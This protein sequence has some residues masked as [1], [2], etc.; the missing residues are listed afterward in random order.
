MIAVV[1]VAA[2]L[3]VAIRLGPIGLVLS[4]P[5]LAVMGALWLVFRGR[6]RLAWFC[7]WVP[8]ILINFL[9]AGLCITPDRPRIGGLA[10]VWLV[11]VFPTVPSLGI[12]WAFLSTRPGAVPQRSVPV[13]WFCV[14][15]LAT[16]PLAT[17][18]TCWPLRLAFFASRP[19][20]EG[21]ADQVAAGK[22]VG[23]P[24]WAGPFRVVGSAV[25]PISGNV[26]LMIDPNPGGPT[27]FVRVS[28]SA[29]PNHLGLIGGDRLDINLG[30]W[31]LY[32]EDD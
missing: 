28:P 27:G 15:V 9:Y 26:R 32:L 21:L 10:V 31:W 7:F 1:A 25:D 13:A 16:L 4:V 29:P 14:I 2:V 24:Q 20:L 12:A 30:R 11:F 18:S 22:P 19:A 6:R 23:F 8:A 3:A 17:F 5:G